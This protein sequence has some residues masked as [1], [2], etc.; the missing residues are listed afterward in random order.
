VSQYQA[1][2]SHWPFHHLADQAIS[3]PFQDP[4]LPYPSAFT[5]HHIDF[6]ID[7]HQVG[8]FYPR[9]VFAVSTFHFTAQIH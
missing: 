6:S 5:D 3:Y 4:Y 7:S 2:F 9:E 1:K 8:A